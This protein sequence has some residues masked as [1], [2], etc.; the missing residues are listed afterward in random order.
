[1]RSGPAVD[2][3]LTVFIAP[4][5]YLTTLE[6]LKVELCSLC[7]KPTPIVH[8][9]LPFFLAKQTHFVLGTRIELFEIS[10]AYHQGISI[11]IIG[12]QVF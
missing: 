7:I 8:Q 10:T 11:I 2:P 3:L 1:M 9:T 4:C 5:I 12:Y 6:V